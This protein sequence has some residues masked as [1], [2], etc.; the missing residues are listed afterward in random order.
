MWSSFPSAA[1]VAL[2]RR[3]HAAHP[4]LEFSHHGDTDAAGYDILRDL[5]QQTGIAIAAHQM[6]YAADATSV[7]LTG[8][9]RARLAR[10]LK[11]PR[12]TAEHADI[13]ALLASGR[14]RA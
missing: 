5:R 7:E 14:H 2:L 12:M 10:L 13:A 1:T 6:R 3:L 4:G 8:D 9:E 11:D